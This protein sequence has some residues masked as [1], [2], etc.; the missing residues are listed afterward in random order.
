M[1][2]SRSCSH[3]TTINIF[4]FVNKIGLIQYSHPLN[5]FSIPIFNAFTYLSEVEWSEG[6]VFVHTVIK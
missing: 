6:V 2:N 4:I 3:K 1:K 5:L